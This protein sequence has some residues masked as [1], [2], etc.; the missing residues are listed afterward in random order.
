MTDTT[1]YN[2]ELRDKN[3]YLKTYLTPF[4][5]KV[6]WEWNRIGGCGRC[7]ITLQKDYRGVTFE[8][9]DDI[10]IRIKDGSTSKLVY[11]G[12]ISNTI[13]TMQVNQNIVLD[14]RGYFDL[15]KKIMVHSSGDTR[16]YLI[17][18]VND[19]ADD[20]ADTFIVAKTPITIAGALTAGDFV[21]DGI[22]FF[23][24]VENALRTLAEIQGNIEYGVD[25]NLV[26]FWN[27]QSDDINHKFF[28]GD[29]VS[30]LERRINWNNLVNKVY[31][32]GGEVSD[33]KYKKTGENTDSQSLYWLNEEI[34]SNSS[35]ITDSVATKYINTILGKKAT[36][37]YNIRGEVKNT[38][39]RMEDTIPMGRLIF[40]DTTY[41]T[42]TVGDIIGE[43]GDG[44]SDITVGE[45]A[46]GGDNVTI[47]GVYSAQIDRISYSLS[48]TPGRFNIKIQLGTTVFETSAKLKQ[49]ELNSA[50]NIQ[51]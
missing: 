6:K 27:T 21:V 1:N 33:V 25:E 19:I 22:E 4:I 48:N 23:G 3:G 20:I 13:P 10:Q 43:S 51:Y 28:V 30:V 29:N 24:T 39:I 11:R 34:I 2:I 37:E 41:D 5:S 38:D 42:T 15:L 26:F 36:P 46:E 8:A 35:I 49:L 17:D 31:L 16:S 47:G 18:T 32:V 14:V 44:G 9:R 40:Y 7:K 50:S 45:T 12:Y